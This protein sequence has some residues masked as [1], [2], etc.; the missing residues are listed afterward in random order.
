MKMILEKIQKIITIKGKRVKNK[1]IEVV[2]FSYGKLTENY[3][4]DKRGVAGL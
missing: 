3:E 4:Q 2:S 1:K